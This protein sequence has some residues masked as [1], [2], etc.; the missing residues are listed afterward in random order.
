MFFNGGDS[1]IDAEWC[2]ETAKT[3]WILTGVFSALSLIPVA[4]LIMA[5]PTSVALYV[6]DGVCVKKK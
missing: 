6:I 2:E 4:G 3:R 1:M 5:A